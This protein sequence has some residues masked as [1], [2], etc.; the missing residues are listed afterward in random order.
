MVFV[1]SAKLQHS[2]ADRMETAR[3]VAGNILSSVSHHSP[4][5]IRKPLYQDVLLYSLVHETGQFPRTMSLFQLYR[6]RQ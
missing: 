2:A 4:P 5:L 6:D 3:R 1:C